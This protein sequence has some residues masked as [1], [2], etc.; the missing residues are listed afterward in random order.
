MAGAAAVAYEGAVA[1]DKVVLLDPGG[2]PAALYV[3]FSGCVVGGA[4]GWY[5]C[6]DTPAAVLAPPCIAP[7]VVAALL[8]GDVWPDAPLYAEGCV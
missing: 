5:C 3:V 4:C 2:T 8:Y 7:A 6:A 1:L